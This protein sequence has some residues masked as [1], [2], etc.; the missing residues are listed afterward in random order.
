MLWARARGSLVDDGYF[1][2][3]DVVRARELPAAVVLNCGKTFS[4]PLT[5]YLPITW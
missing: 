4:Q 1:F 3:K 2:L 5:K